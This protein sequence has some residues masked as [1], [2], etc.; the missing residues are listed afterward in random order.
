[1]HTERCTLDGIHAWRRVTIEE[2]TTHEGDI[3]A[4]GTSH[5]KG[6]THGGDMQKEGVCNVHTKGHAEGGM[7]VMYTRRD[8]YK[9]AKYKTR[10]NQTRN[11]EMEGAYT[12]RESSDGIRTMEPV[13]WNAP[14]ES[15]HII[16]KHM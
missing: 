14:M 11:T 13:R 6:N 3:H 4:V 10:D 7:Y 2:T 16:N 5:T 8:I 12:R 1:M 15:A 9:D